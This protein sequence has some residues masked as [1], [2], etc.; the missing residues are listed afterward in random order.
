M[1]RQMAAFRN[2]LLAAAL[3]AGFLSAACGSDVEITT[4]SLPNA[5]VGISYSYQLAGNNV[6]HWALLSGVLPPGIQLNSSG[7]LSGTPALAGVYSFTVQALH[8]SS[9]GPTESLAM[10]LAL[11]V[12]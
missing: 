11:T 7:M 8:Q 6:E 12:R 5:T 3:A 10:G 2:S 9:T 4:T 1:R